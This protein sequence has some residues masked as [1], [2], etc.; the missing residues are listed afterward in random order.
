MFTKLKHLLHSHDVAEM[1]EAMQHR[2]NVILTVTIVSTVIFD[3]LSFA[4]KGAQTALT[5]GLNG[6][7]IGLM[8]LYFLNILPRSYHKKK[9]KF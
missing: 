6:L 9:D 2:K 5:F 1:P 7:A 8:I 4:I 3:I